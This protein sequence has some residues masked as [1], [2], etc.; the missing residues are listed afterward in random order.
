MTE[1]D[2]KKKLQE[3][4]GIKREADKLEKAYEEGINK[5]VEAPGLGGGM[6]QSGL[7]TR[8]SQHLGS[9]PAGVEVKQEAKDMHKKIINQLKA[10]PKPNLPKSELDKASISMPMGGGVRMSG[11]NIG[12]IGVTDPY[13]KNKKP[14]NT[15]TVITGTMGAV[16]GT[17]SGM[18][19][20][21]G[22][23][24]SEKP[25]APPH[26]EDIVSGVKTP[27][28]LKSFSSPVPYDHPH[29]ELAAKFVTDVWR[30]NRSEGMRMSDK[31]LGIG[32]GLVAGHGEKQHKET[33]G[34]IKKADMK[35]IPADV[36]EP[37]MEN[38]VDSQ[39]PKEINGPQMI[40]AYKSEGTEATG[41][42]ML[43]GDIMKA[44]KRKKYGPS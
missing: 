16:G 25:V 36:S 10:M 5:P 34:N 40:N 30:K 27:H 18:G 14:K 43:V 21:S 29:R 35:A 13:K 33:Y 4:L 1:F 3:W 42:L 23:A 7:A 44:L 17:S 31:Y 28:E 9:H 11:I 2:L 15:S 6:S 12:N 32:Q 20:A 8:M 24:A 38:R 22:L 39:H 41:N 19:G 26:H 37:I